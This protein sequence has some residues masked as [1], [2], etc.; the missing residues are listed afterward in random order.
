MLGYRPY[1]STRTRSEESYKSFTLTPKMVL[2]VLKHMLSQMPSTKTSIEHVANSASQS[3][4]PDS[5]SLAIYLLLLH[6]L[7]SMQHSMAWHSTAQHSTA[8]HRTAQ[9][10]TAQPSTAQ[11]SPAQHSTAQ[12]S[13][14]Q[15]S[16]AQAWYIANPTA[17]LLHSQRLEHEQAN[18]SAV[19]LLSNRHQGQIEQSTPSH[20]CAR[21][22]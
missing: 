5:C 22:T 9:H 18:N 8:Q 21:M 15:H 1:S 2:H 14:A 17:H 19:S 13:T 20:E 16:A 4:N 3:L 12:H 6:S 10:S 7:R 11:P